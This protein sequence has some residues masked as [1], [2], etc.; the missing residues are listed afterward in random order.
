MKAAPTPVATRPKKP[1]RPKQNTTDSSFWSIVSEAKAREKGKAKATPEQD[2]DVAPEHASDSSLYATAAS[3]SISAA[4]PLTTRHSRKRT[5]IENPLPDSGLGEPPPTKRHK[6]GSSI[7]APN[8]HHAKTP[9]AKRIKPPI[10]Q[11]PSVRRIKLIVRRPNPRLT[12]PDQ[13]WPLPSY[14]GSL[15]EVL[16]SFPS[17]DDEDTSTADLK[18]HAKKRAIFL[19]KVASLRKQGRLLYTPD[20]KQ[21]ELARTGGDIWDHVLEDIDMRAQSRPITSR[22]GAAQVAN[23]IKAYWESQA[24]KEDK[25]RAQEE[26]R[27][28]IL[29]K[30][31]IK[32]V[33]AKWKEAVLHI[34]EEER[35]I[36]LEEERRRGH[37]HLDDI[38]TRSGQ[39]L[40]AQQA[41]LSKAELTV[42]SR[43]QSSSLVTTPLPWT[44]FPDASD[45]EDADSDSDNDDT[46]RDSDDEDEEDVDTAGLLGSVASP[47]ATPAPH[48]VL[49]LRSSPAP[50]ESHSSRSA[51]PSHGS[52][53]MLMY[54]EDT[55]ASSPI[56]PASKSFLSDPF[57]EADSF[58]FP[59]EP[60]QLPV[61]INEVS[62]KLTPLTKEVSF[63]D[64]HLSE[65]PS[66]PPLS[67]EGAPLTQD[68]QADILDEQIT[69]LPDNQEPAEDVDSDDA[70]D[71]D[72]DLLA[73]IPAYLR[74]YAVAPVDW[75]PQ[76]KVLPPLLLRGTLRPYQHAGLEWL[77]NIHTNNLNGILADEMGLG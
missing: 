24:I 17:L 39:I 61:G 30:A 34:R 50:L 57:L 6:L 35:Q 33:V 54:P 18:D 40:E 46:A 28:R 26:K 11:S 70:H 19:N 76:Q 73:S 66:S 74:P 32:M 64:V 14:G 51:T 53:E 48:E 3:D 49:S 13:K 22:Q 16:H 45:D 37:E 59:H 60:L 12:N 55:D 63:A 5:V 21:Q 68:T 77:A 8:L 62:T 75:D 25:L 69:D 41:K 31:T 44:A 56:E 7:S 29:A 42:S 47:S 27:L 71:I 72:D 67:A 52:L 2:N 15:T 23:R 58:I 65:V 36:A 9:V 10:A 4:R 1:P 38:L 20:S 43:S